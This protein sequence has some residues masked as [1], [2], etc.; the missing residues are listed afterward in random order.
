M[1]TRR[2]VV[3]AV[4]TGLLLASCAEEQATSPGSS[5]D[6]QQQSCATNDLPLFEPGTLTVATDD[7]AFPPWFEGPRRDY[8]GGYEG[9]L[10]AEVADR[11]GLPLEWV[12][13]PFNKS[14]APGQ[15]DYDF[16]I[17]Q[18]SITPERDQVVDF[19]DGYFNN[20]QG[21]L[22]LEGTPITDATTVEDLKGYQL[23]TQVGTTSLNFINT[24]IQPEA[25]TKTFDTTNDAKSA[26]DAGQIDALVTDLVTT[27]YL[28]DFEIK[29]SVVVG[30]YPTDE[31]F[32]MLFEQ[33]NP[34]G[35]CVNKAL[36]EIKGDGTLKKLQEKWLQDYLSVPTV[37]DS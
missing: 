20:N 19:S 31:Q 15:K 21:I 30:Q 4:T 6:G 11:L 26:L 27:V 34:L 28:R 17:N 10:A 9:D 7:P 29:G 36:S 1:D 3:A 12:T 8:N 23:G 2:I 5:G 13:E 14:Y 35:E 33:G 24:V 16:D 37:T 32:G 18:I 22:A 25:G